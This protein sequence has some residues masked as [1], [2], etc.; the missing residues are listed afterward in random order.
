VRVVRFLR[1]CYN[2]SVKIILKMGLIVKIPFRYQVT[3]CDCVPTTFI[4]ALQYLFSR[5]EIPPAV[6]QK[7]MLY[8]LDSINQYGEDGKN[9]TTGLA[10]QLI[11]Q[12]LQSFSNDKFALDCEYLPQEQIHL[13]RGNK[14]IS[15]INRGG[16]ALLRVKAGKAKTAPFHYMLALGVDGDDRDWLLFFDPYYRVKSFTGEDAEYLKWLGGSNPQGANLRIKRERLDSCENAKY[17][18]ASVDERE[19]CL[20]ERV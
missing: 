14:I 9:G 3:N 16:V 8:S 4:N 6:I 20:L 17:S 1:L 2:I 13:R 11:M 12:W 18:M 5:D 15:C 19:C 10:I 7:I